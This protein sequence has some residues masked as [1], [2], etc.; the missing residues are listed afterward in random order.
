[1]DFQNP[2][3]PPVEKNPPKFRPNGRPAVENEKTI[4][5]KNQK[6]IFKRYDKTDF[7]NDFFRIFATFTYK[8]AYE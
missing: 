7:T 6:K 3:R 8:G 5:F 1:M 2:F 4:F